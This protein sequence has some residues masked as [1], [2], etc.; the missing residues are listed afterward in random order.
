MVDTS[1]CAVRRILNDKLRLKFDS[2]D[3]MAS[4]WKSFFRMNERIDRF[5]SPEHLAKFVTGI[6]CKKVQAEN[7][8]RLHLK[9]HNIGREVPLDCSPGDDGREIASRDPGPVEM[10]IVRERWEQLLRGKHRRYRRII[11]LKLQGY[12]QTEIAEVLRI[13]RRSVSRFIKKLLRA[14]VR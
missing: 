14:T 9:K 8:R 10:A 6:A 3:F 2:D 1:S 4:A 12:R 7:R 5:E 11:E 13:N